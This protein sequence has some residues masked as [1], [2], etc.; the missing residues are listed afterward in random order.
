MVRYVA[1]NCKLEHRSGFL[2]ASHV[3]KEQG[4][5][6]ALALRAAT[7]KLLLEVGCPA[8]R[9][10]LTRN[11]RTQYTKALPR[12]LP[13]IE[14]MVADGA[15]DEQLALNFMFGGAQVVQWVVSL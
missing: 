14:A 5:V 12:M 1:A 8:V 4:H 10:P 13:K 2:G 15:S 3:A 7:E 11:E 9:M 6:H